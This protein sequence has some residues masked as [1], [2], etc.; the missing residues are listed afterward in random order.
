MLQ[1][2]NITVYLQ[3][4]GAHYLGANAYKENEIELSLVYSGGTIK[5][6]YTQA[7]SSDYNDGIPTPDFIS[8]INSFMPIL[9]VPQPPEQYDTVVTFLS[10]NNDTFCGKADFVLPSWPELGLLQISVPITINNTVFQ[11]HQQ[12]LLNPGQPSYNITIAVPGLFLT[13]NQVNNTGLSVYVKMMCGCPI[14]RA[15]DPKPSLWHDNDFTV[16]A[17][18]LD[19]TGKTTT[20]PLT[21]EEPQ[22]ANSL[23]SIKFDKPLTTAIISVTF[24]AIQKSIGNYGAVVAEG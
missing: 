5:I 16:Y 8:G 6:P 22:P 23:F 9:T 14:T 7:N 15:G 10:H 17:N 2:G 13:A 12:V 1:Q 24:T 3:A 19:E 4:L 18:V 11:I 21:Y 20:Y